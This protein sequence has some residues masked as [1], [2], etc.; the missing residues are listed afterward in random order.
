M[1]HFVLTKVGISAHKLM[2]QFRID[3]RTAQG[4]LP[5]AFGKNGLSFP[6]REM[7]GSKQ[8]EA[9]RQ[10]QTGINS[11]GDMTGIA[12]RRVGND[13]A[14]RSARRFLARRSERGDLA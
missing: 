12:I 11:A 9:P 4:G 8:K 10:F 7:P 2:R 1:R 13:T 3:F 6:A 5:R 14:D